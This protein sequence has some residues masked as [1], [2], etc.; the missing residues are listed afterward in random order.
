MRPD[1]ALRDGNDLVVKLEYGQTEKPD[2]VVA[3]QHLLLVHV[4]VKPLIE[5]AHA[6]DPYVMR[7]ALR[8]PVEPHVAEPSPRGTQ[9]ERSIREHARTQDD[10]GISI[11]HRED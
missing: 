10:R 3:P 11:R 4:D 6:P 9:R 8:Q 7:A 1:R 5:G 2:R